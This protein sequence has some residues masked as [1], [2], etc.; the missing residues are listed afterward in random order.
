MEQAFVL[1]VGKREKWLAAFQ[2]GPGDGLGLAAGR[3]VWDQDDGGEAGD[4]LRIWALAL[5]VRLVVGEGRHQQQ[6][7]GVDGCLP[8]FGKA[9]P[10][11]AFRCND[12]HRL[13]T[14]Q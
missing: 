12:D 3:S 8:G 7:A 11:N 6:A 1:L 4:E 13:L 10:R 5:V 9:R 14:A 2:D